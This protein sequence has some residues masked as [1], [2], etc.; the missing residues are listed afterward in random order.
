MNDP[1]TV[2]VF[3]TPLFISVITTLSQLAKVVHFEVCSF[4][5]QNRLFCVLAVVR[6]NTGCLD[7]TQTCSGILNMFL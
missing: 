5:P 2:A 1:L 7:V 6:S 3:G 4:D